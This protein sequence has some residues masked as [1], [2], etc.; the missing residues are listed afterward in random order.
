MK[1]LIDKIRAEGIA[2][3]EEVLKVDSFI[4]HQVDTVLM[5]RIGETFAEHFKNH[6]ITKVLTVESSGIAPAVFAAKHMGLDL[7]VLK[8][9]TSKILGGE[10]YQSTVSSFTKGTRYELTLAK[11]FIS[12][13]DRVLFIDDFLANG[14]A[15]MGFVQ[16]MEKAGAKIGGIGILIEKSFQ[17]GRKML[18]DLG[19]DVYSLARIRKMNE[20]MITFES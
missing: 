18:D 7:V 8:K 1:E 16:L 6:G 11:K 2:L 19:L 14:Q 9:S 5:D 12:P 4:N 15:A 17:S 10:V 3:N 20:G 13:E